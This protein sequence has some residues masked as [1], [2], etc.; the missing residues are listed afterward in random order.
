MRLNLAIVRL[1]ELIQPHDELIMRLNLVILRLDLVIQV[2]YRAMLRLNLEI[3][4]HTIQH[5]AMIASLDLE[6]A[7]FCGKI[8]SL[9]PWRSHFCG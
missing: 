3:L 2:D 5:C 7:L 8:S 9:W 6:I 1:N 4:R